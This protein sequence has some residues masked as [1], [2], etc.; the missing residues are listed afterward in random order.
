MKVAFISRHVPTQEQIAAFAKA[1]HE[2]VHVGDCDGFDRVAVA[3][4]MEGFDG[5]CVVH[6]GAAINCVVS[7]E[8][9]F[10]VFVCE[11][12]NR[13]PAGE[14]PQFRLDRVHEWRW[15]PGDDGRGELIYGLMA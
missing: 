7:A 5:A 8:K 12:S 4:F 2:L 3:E 10:S 11:N 9:D 1:G 14:P 15:R 13:A 6:A